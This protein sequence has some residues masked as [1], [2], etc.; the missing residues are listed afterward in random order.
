MKA[1]WKLQTARM[2]C[3]HCGQ[4]VWMVFK[5]RWSIH[6]MKGDGAID[7]YSEVGPSDPPTVVRGTKTSST[8]RT[9]GGAVDDSPT[10]QSP[11]LYSPESEP[12]ERAEDDSD[13]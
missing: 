7:G 11:S 3:P 4:T 2:R 13:G 9:R 8:A 1:P 10:P 5:G 12:I 6:R